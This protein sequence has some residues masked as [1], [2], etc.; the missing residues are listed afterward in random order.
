CCTPAYPASS[1]WFVLFYFVIR[2]PLRPPLFPYTTLF[3]SLGGI[4]D[5][6]VAEC[7]GTEDAVPVTVDTRAVGETRVDGLLVRG[8]RSERGEPLRSL[9]G[10]AGGVHDQVGLDRPG[11]RSCPVAAFAQEHATHT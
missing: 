3:R 8:L 9:R 2:R 4:G 5:D 1:A 10:A 11:L 7:V 6:V